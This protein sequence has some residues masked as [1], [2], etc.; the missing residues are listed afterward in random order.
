ML[1]ERIEAKRHISCNYSM[2]QL[3]GAPHKP[4]RGPKSTLEIFNFPHAKHALLD[5]SSEIAI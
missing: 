3:K 1:Y 4:P 5:L 2:R